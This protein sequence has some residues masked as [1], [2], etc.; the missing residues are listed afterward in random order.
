[1][2]G[3]RP[4]QESRFFRFDIQNFRNVTALGVHAPLRVL[5]PPTGN[6]GSATGYC[7]PESISLMYLEYLDNNLRASSIISVII[8]FLTD[9]P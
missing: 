9:F 7:V 1:M 4:P 8:T 6:P 5:R 3:A 2:P